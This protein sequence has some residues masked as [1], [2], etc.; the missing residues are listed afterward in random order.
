[1]AI[2]MKLKKANESSKLDVSKFFGIPTLPL[3]IIDELSSDA[4]FIAQIKLEDIIPFDIDNK[5]PH[6]GFLYFFME[7]EDDSPYSYKKAVVLYS[8]EEPEVAISDFNQ[9]SPISEGLNEDYIIEF[10]K[11]DDSYEG[12]KLLGVPADWNYQDEPR[13]L[14][15]QY[16]PLDTEDLEF[17]SCL[18]GYIYFFFKDEKRKFNEVEIQLEYS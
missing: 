10:F 12:N 4:I 13:E 16:D 8:N 15:L 6:V 7:S 1:M 18:D 5:L 3:S 14:L 11:A 2:G 9:N 17:F